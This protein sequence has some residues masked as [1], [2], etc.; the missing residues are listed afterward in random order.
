MLLFELIFP[1]IFTKMSKK[2]RNKFH[3][4]TVEV[5]LNRISNKTC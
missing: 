4:V 2:I 3:T 5:V 1:L